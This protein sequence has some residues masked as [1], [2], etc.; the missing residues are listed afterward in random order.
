MQRHAT[1][2]MQTIFVRSKNLQQELRTFY[3]WYKNNLQMAQGGAVAQGIALR[4]RELDLYMFE[5]REE[6]F[7]N[8]FPAKLLILVFSKDHY[9]HPK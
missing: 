4:T 9:K 3:S 1:N 8:G 7:A 6:N 2:H 5:S